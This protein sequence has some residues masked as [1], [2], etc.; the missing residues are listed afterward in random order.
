MLGNMHCNKGTP[1]TKTVHVFLGSQRS[2]TDSYCHFIAHE[3]QNNN[4]KFSMRLTGVTIV[5]TYN[6]WKQWPVIFG[7]G[8][9]CDCY[10]V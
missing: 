4:E 6:I 9:G 5:A 1:A 2:R 10:L 8:F 7:D 3:T